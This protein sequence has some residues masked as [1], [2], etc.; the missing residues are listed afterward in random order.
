VVTKSSPKRYTQRQL[1][2]VFLASS[3]IP[4][5]QLSTW[6]RRIWFNPVD[7]ESLRLNLVGYQFL[8]DNVKLKGYEYKLKSPLSSKNLIQLERY[9]QGPY[10]LFQNKKI[11]VFDET[12]ASMLS[13]MD[14]DLRSYLE[15]LEIN[16]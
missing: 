12:E 4:V 13:L 2:E 5:Q 3:N 15:N 11:I 10:Y 6:Q 1:T 14:G 9:F 16:T 8:M 7:N